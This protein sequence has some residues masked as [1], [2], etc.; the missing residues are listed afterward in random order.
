MTLCAIREATALLVSGA[1]L[2]VSMPYYSL[3]VIGVTAGIYVLLVVCSSM[4]FH[5]ARCSG[6]V[7]EPREIAGRKAFF[8]APECP[9]QTL[10]REAAY[11]GKLVNHDADAGRTWRADRL[12]AR[13]NARQG[14]ELAD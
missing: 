7:V 11:P 4:V 9:A 8:I 6:L 2:T 12:R 5:A 14:F 3:L 10:V 13:V 1:L